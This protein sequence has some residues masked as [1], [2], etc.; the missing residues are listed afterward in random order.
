M[1]PSLFHRRNDEARIL[2]H[3][4]LGPTCR[5]RLDAGIEAHALWAMLVDVAEGRAL[6][7]A[8]GVIGERHGDRHVDAYHADL[9][10]AG[11]FARGIAVA[12]EDG[13]TVAVLVV[14]G[15]RHRLIEILGARDLQN[16]SENFFL[17]GF[18][19]RLDA[20]EQRAAEIKSLLVAL[21]LEAT[22]IDQKL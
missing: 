16:G 19:L 5:H 10:L 22:P 17:I 21:H 8:E 14:A 18:H 13:D 11:E 20:I 12:G 3:A 9:H 7:A 15:K 1:T 6:P 4:A 2:A